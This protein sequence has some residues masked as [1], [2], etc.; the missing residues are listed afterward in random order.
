MIFPV[1]SRVGSAIVTVWRRLRLLD[2]RRLPPNLSMLRYLVILMFALSLWSCVDE[3]WL[4]ATS[5]PPPDFSGTLRITARSA[6]DSPLRLDLIVWRYPDRD[7]IREFRTDAN[8]YADIVLSPGQ[9][10]LRCN[11]P[12]AYW[13]PAGMTADPAASEAVFTVPRDGYVH[14]EIRFGGILIR[15]LDTEQGFFLTCCGA[16]LWDIG[17][18]MITSY[19]STDEGPLYDLLVPGPFFVRNEVIG[20]ID[21]A[22]A[23]YSENGDPYRPDTVWIESGPPRIL[24]FPLTYCGF[25]EIEFVSPHRGRNP[26]GVI[27]VPIS[28]S[29][30]AI[31]QPG[32]TISGTHRILIGHLHPGDYSVRIIAGGHRGWYSNG[33]MV[34][35]E[36]QV[37]EV[38]SRERTGG[39][40]FSLSGL[41]MEARGPLGEQVLGTEF[42]VITEGW[43]DT[44]SAQHRDDLDLLVPTGRHLVRAVPQLGDRYIA[45]WWP[46]ALTHED[47]QWVELEAGETRSLEFQLDV[48]GSIAGRILD[49][50]GGMLDAY[51]T[52]VEAFDAEGKIA[53]SAQADQAGDF[54]LNGLPPGRFKVLVHPGERLSSFVETWYPSTTNPDSAVAIAVEPPERVDGVDV[55]LQ[56]E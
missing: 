8:G 24:D 22:N 15:A 3:G 34:P 47:A 49:P 53:S 33:R 51:K 12:R 19:E 9:Y 35:G 40:T 43:P 16:A 25:I 7:Y 30:Y 21:Y 41:E 37:L 1:V 46:N 52:D 44:V 18:E 45:E 54:L 20:R 36:P 50:D 5:P 26:L 38:V 17:G 32:V 23:W 11:D 6:S 2:A 42:A 4:S 56:L 39:L 14:A 10:Q 27:G 48:G 28:D 13:T 31:E 55:N 29:P